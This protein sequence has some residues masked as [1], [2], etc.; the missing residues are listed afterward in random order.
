[1]SN[2]STFV[3]ATFIALAA[4]AGLAAAH[5]WRN[6]APPIL[7]IGSYLPARALPEFSLIDQHGK[8]FTRADL[9]GHWSLMFFGYTNCPDL[10]PTTLTTLA[11]LEKTLRAADEPV[12]P[13]VVFISVDTHRDTPEQLARYLPNFD[14][15]FIGLT[16]PSQPAVEAMAAGMG[17]V[18]QTRL[19]SDGTYSVDHSAAILVVDPDGRLRAILT[20]PYSVDALRADLRRIV[21][22]PA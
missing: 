6:P 1:M 19:Q 17:V 20:G 8:G 15:Q 14:P 9:R 2:R 3:T 11:S 12:V 22:A 7:A 4:A 13:Q 21:D 10:C 18:A 5:Y 16:S